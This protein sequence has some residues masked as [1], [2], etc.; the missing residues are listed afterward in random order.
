MSSTACVWGSL[1]IK[2]GAPQ[3]RLPGTL[4]HAGGRRRT[5]VLP[6]EEVPVAELLR[7]GVRRDVVVQVH[8]LR[9]E[10]LRHLGS[11]HCGRVGG[12]GDEVKTGR[13]SS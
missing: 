1:H 6:V 11:H 13:Q 8:Q 9:E 2:E 10:V 12:R 7:C 3:G 5:A 4:R